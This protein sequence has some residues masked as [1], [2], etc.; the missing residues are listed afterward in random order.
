[1]LDNRCMFQCVQQ[2]T[3][4]KASGI[5]G[6]TVFSLLSALM[7]AKAHVEHKGDSKPSW[8]VGLNDKFILV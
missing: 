6:T 2:Q 7:F 5:Q 8:K 3:G 4:N 1:M